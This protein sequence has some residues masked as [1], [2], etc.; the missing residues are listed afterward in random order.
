MTSLN[1]LAI[2]LKDTREPVIWDPTTSQDPTTVPSRY[3]QCF[4]RVV[5]QICTALLV[6]IHP[7]Y[8]SMADSDP[9]IL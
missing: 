1:D 5:L 2:D 4:S 3:I 6:L 7:Y 9:S 8:S